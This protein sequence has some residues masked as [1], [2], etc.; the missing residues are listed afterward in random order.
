MLI[1][2]KNFCIIFQKLNFAWRQKLLVVLLSHNWLM[3]RLCDGTPDKLYN[4]RACCRDMS[5]YMTRL[6]ALASLSP[7]A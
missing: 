4:L 5:I 3:I 7:Y 2:I 1:R 6:F